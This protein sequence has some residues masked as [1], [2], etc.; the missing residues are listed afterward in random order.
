L[1]SFLLSASGAEPFLNC[2]AAPTIVTHEVGCAASDRHNGRLDVSLSLR[3]QWQIARTFASLQPQVSTVLAIHPQPPGTPSPASTLPFDLPSGAVWLDL[4]NGTDAEKG[5]VERTTGMRVPSLED[6]REIESSS[7]LVADGDVLYLS[8]PIISRGEGARPVVSPLGLVLSPRHLLTVRFAPIG[9]FDTFAKQF[10]AGDDAS[11]SFGAFI[12]LLEAMVDRIAD[13]LE[14]IRA[15]LDEIS[16]TAFEADEPKRRAPA[17][18]DAAL[19]RALRSIG[20]MGEQTSNVRDT[21]LGVERIA[22][23]VMETAKEWIPPEYLP[24]VR[25]LRQDIASLNDYDAQMA[26]KVQFLLDA[27][28]GFISIEQNNT[29]KLLTVVSLVGIPPTLVA[30]IYG[31]NFKFMPEL[32]WILGY[33]F[34]LGLIVLSAI[35]PLLL[36][37]LRGWL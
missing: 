9:S 23:F 26:N 12:G 5:F 21:L 7:R 37:K 19:R 18:V 29:I 22:P 4:F 6:L 13:A 20:R 31:M 34:G 33:P 17:R 1:H 30:G 27:T 15:Q 11:C 24:R 3:S 10:G 25:T 36:F 35:L 2:P 16:Q 8:T 28:L 14:R 32:D